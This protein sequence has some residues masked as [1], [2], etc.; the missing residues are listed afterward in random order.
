MTHDF[1]DRFTERPRMRETQRARRGHAFLPAAVLVG[2]PGR[3]HNRP[4]RL[5]EA[6]IHLHYFAGGCDWWIAEAW[7]ETN[8][9]EVV[10]L[11]FGYT[12]LG[13]VPDG[14]EWGLV[15]LTELE[16]VN[17]RGGLVVVERDLS[18]Q[19]CPAHDCV[20]DLIQR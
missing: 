11:A 15:S 12:R 19:P 7:P 13:H 9:N 1:A 2:L 14:A 20:P 18:W 5:G 4:A 17:V 16:Q 8:G 6:T 3:G 10:W